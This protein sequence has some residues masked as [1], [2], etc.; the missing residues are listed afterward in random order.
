M[1]KRE[2]TTD[3]DLRLAGIVPPREV[4][5]QHTQH[6]WDSRIGAYLK[7]H[8]EPAFVEEGPVPTALELRIKNEEVPE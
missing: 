1:I 3:Y 7:E 8:H 5:P 6:E 2:T 4:E